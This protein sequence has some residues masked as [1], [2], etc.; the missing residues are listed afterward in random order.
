MNSRKPFFAA[1]LAADIAA[2]MSPAGAQTGP[3]DVPSHPP[4]TVYVQ[5]SDARF[6]SYL[7]VKKNIFP[8]NEAD[9]SDEFFYIAPSNSKERERELANWRRRFNLIVSAATLSESVQPKISHVKAEFSRANS[10]AECWTEDK[11]KERRITITMIGS[12]SKTAMENEY[13]AVSK[14][15]FASPEN[16]ICKYTY[17]VDPSTPQR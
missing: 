1:V 9:S 6:D 11:N 3:Q 10:A 17:H 8:N 5:A 16:Y 14:D 15:F 7:Y 12:A 4:I 2:V 13:R